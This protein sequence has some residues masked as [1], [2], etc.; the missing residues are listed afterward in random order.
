MEHKAHSRMATTTSTG[1]HKLGS[2]VLMLK[3]QS[4]QNCHG[5]LGLS[6]SCNHIAGCSALPEPSELTAKVRGSSVLLGLL[7]LQLMAILKALC[8]LYLLARCLAVCHQVLAA[9]ECETASRDTRL[10][11]CEGALVGMQCCSIDFEQSGLM[12][13][14]RIPDSSSWSLVF[15][16]S[17]LT[18]G[19]S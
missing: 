8:V 13:A 10:G 18:L 1:M 17:P 6:T 4:W 14:S 7:L 2:W 9:C 5:C 15:F 12:E 3:A 11:S 19:L 16:G